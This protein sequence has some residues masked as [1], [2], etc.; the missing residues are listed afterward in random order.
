MTDPRLAV[1]A[2]HGILG[3][4]ATTSLATYD[5]RGGREAA[6][7]AVRG[8][9]TPRARIEALAHAVGHDAA[10]AAHILLTVWICELCETVHHSRAAYLFCCD[11]SAYGEAD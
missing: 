11:E 8:K 7:H 10:R 1:L 2:E 9:H 4:D 5:K 3:D 6:A